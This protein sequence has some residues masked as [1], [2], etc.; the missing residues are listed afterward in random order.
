MNT[1][2]KT[3]WN[4]SL[5]AYMAVSEL[6]SG[7]AKSS[8]TRRK[9]RNPERASAL[10]L[11][12]EPRIVFDGAL[13][14]EAAHV[15]IADG[16]A[17]AAA[18]VT[19]AAA[20][21][22]PRVQAAADTDKAVLDSAATASAPNALLFIDSHVADLQTLIAGAK[23]GEQVWV[24]NPNSDGVQQIADVIAANGLHDLSAIH[25]VSHGTQGQVQLGSTW[26]DAGNLGGHAQVL[27][28]I[29]LSLTPDGDLQIGRA[30][31]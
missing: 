7:R 4:D 3:V 15:D 10:R 13:A 20:E 1:I 9:L 14:V 8:S 11:A 6:A 25:I 16:T 22:A 2:F 19:R 29:G 23:P 28:D 5:G 12:L 18:P 30:H 27:A 21:A 31:V 24:L 17:S 26:L